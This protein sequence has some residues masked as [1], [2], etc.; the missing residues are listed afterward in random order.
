MIV[1]PPQPCETMC[2]AFLLSGGFMVSLTSGVKLQ[3]FILDG[4][5]PQVP[6]R[7]RS[8]AGFT[9]HWHWLWDFAAPS[10]GTP[11]AWRKLLP[12][13][14]K[15]KRGSEKETETRH[16]GQRPREEGRAVHTRD[17]ASD[18]AQQG[19]RS[20]PP[21]PHTG[22]PALRAAPAPARASLFTL[23]R[24]QREPAQ[25]SASPREGPS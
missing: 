13:N 16:H 25:A 15:E 20:R 12:D 18:Q 11:A 10:P 21:G 5:V 23:P 24:E 17:P 22:R 4:K 19:P 9:S 1:R 2:P 7:P 14:Q 3:T 6:T 8:P